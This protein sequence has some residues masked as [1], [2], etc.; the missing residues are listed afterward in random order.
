[1]NMPQ[2]IRLGLFDR[3]VCAVSPKAG[4]ERVR[5]R[6]ALQFM[7]DSGFV[8]PGSPRRSMRGYLP[9]ANTAD[10]DIISKLQAMRAG[11]RDLYYNTPGATAPIRRFRTNVVGTGLVL[12]SQINR[13][14]L[15][16]SNEK[17]DEW[18]RNVEREFHAW[19]NT[20][21]C[22]ITRTQN[23][24]ELTGLSFLSTMLSGDVFVALPRVPRKG[25][26][27]DLRIKL[28]EADDCS[29]PNFSMDTNRIA[30]GVETDANGAPIAYHFKYT[31]LN[32]SIYAGAFN[33]KRVPAFGRRSGLRQVLH[34]FERERPGQ[35]RGVPM[36]APVTEQLKQLTRYSLAE[37]DAAILNSFFTVFV[38]TLPPQGLQQG[39]V[40]GVP[41]VMG[42]SII[43]GGPGAPTNPADEKVYEIGRGVINELDENQSI[44]LADPKHPVAGFGAFF[45]AYMKQISASLEIPFEVVMLHFNSSYSAARAALLEAWRSFIFKRFFMARNFCQPIY[46]HW[47]YDAVLKGRISAPGF[48]SDPAIR[49]AWLGS[50][51]IGPGKGMIDPLKEVRAARQK[52]DGRLSTHEDEFLQM[53]ETGGDWEGAMHRL[54]REKVFLEDND[55]GEDTDDEGTASNDEDLTNV[56]TTN[57]GD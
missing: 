24:Y 42:G 41:P 16:L 2:P 4:L 44:E 10:Q 27:Y 3:F 45:E 32:D 50:A 48:L 23:F 40:P 18:E 31:E 25:Q 1:M 35:R 54:S 28:I 43:P 38:K 5:S 46:T 34:L 8:T 52:I 17:A 12:R 47:M 7:G 53:Q 22:D 26:V 15:G 51:W 56:D 49:Q 6:A 14:L 39:F 20:E 36:L 33:W 30:G 37:I 55:L 11:S 9:S 57:H 21:E 29:N 19:A 13:N